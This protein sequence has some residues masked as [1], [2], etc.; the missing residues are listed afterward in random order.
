MIDTLSMALM[1]WKTAPHGPQRSGTVDHYNHRQPH[2][3]L[4]NVTPADVY[5]G[6]ATSILK[7]REKIKEQTIQ[8]RRLTH[9]GLVA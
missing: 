2:E 4:K 7:R 8:H 9:L 3:S 5:F 6:R 1:D